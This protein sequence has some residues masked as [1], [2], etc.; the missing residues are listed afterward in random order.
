MEKT[1]QET[2][3]SSLVCS[4]V[5]VRLLDVRIDGRSVHPSGS[6][7]FLIERYTGVRSIR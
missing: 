3:A 6:V 1:I 2:S 5:V 7:R 4:L